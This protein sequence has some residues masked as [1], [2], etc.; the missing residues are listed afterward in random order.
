MLFPIELYTDDEVNELVSIAKNDRKNGRV[1]QWTSLGS[2]ASMLYSMNP[3][4]VIQG[5]LQYFRTKY[6]ET[7]GR[8]MK[9]GQII[10]E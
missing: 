8:P 5:A 2:G 10:Y 3:N 7:Y 1:T 9:T 6:P 4:D